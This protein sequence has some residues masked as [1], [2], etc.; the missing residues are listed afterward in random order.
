[1]FYNFSSIYFD[2]LQQI[3]FYL[4]TTEIHAVFYGYMGFK[5]SFTQKKIIFQ[6]LYLF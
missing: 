6:H 2:F 3:Y 5:F 4:H 1:M